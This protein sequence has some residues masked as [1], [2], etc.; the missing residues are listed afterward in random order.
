MRVLQFRRGS[1]ATVDARIP[2]VGEIMVD[3]DRSELRLGDG[4]TPGGKRILNESQLTLFGSLLYTGA[5]SV[6]TPGTLTVAQT[7]RK[8]L[9]LTAPGNFRLPAIADLELGAPIVIMPTSA[10]VNLTVE[11]GKTIRHQGVDVTSLPLN[12]D[13]V[14]LLTKLSTTRFQVLF[15][16]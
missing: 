12:D 11:A 2:A 4:T 15:R 13:E 14:T 10:G 9:Q 5:V 16:Y 3:T 7:Q 1:T 6:G 8:F